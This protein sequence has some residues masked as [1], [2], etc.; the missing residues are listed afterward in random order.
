MY[1]TVH[2]RIF[3]WM[4][5]VP[6][7]LACY[8]ATSP[9]FVGRRILIRWQAYELTRFY[10]LESSSQL[11]GPSRRRVSAS[12]NPCTPRLGTPSSC[13]CSAARCHHLRRKSNHATPSTALRRRG[14]S[15][16]PRAPRLAFAPNLQAKRASS[17]C[18]S[19]YVHSA[20]TGPN[21]CF[22]AADFAS[23]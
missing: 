10:F 7:S 12:L 18:Y 4:N 21:Y 16:E 1:H 9:L 20:S 14:R 15:R 11:A 6:G 8:V 3:Y 23:S 19:R 2:T 22:T 13:S 17:P 5:F